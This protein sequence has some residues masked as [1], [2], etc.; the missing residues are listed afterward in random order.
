LTALAHL[1]SGSFP[2]NGAW[3][4]LAAIAHNLTR[5]AGCLAGQWHA[6][7]R[8][9]TIRGHLIGVA[10]RIARRGRGEITLHLPEGW[11]AGQEWL[12]LFEAACGPPRARAA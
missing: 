9:A 1:P 11:H 5:A 7:A 10:A 3:L 12:S 4:A 8:G 6:A 2:A